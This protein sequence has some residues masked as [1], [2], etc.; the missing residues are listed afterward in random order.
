MLQLADEP[1]WESRFPASTLTAHLYSITV[2]GRE[3]SDQAPLL[4]TIS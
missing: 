1:N 2:H 4:Q 3:S